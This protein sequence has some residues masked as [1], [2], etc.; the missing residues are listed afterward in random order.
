LQKLQDLMAET[1]GSNSRNFRISWQKLQELMAETSGFNGRNFRISWQL[2]II[3]F[4]QYK[5]IYTEESSDAS[6]YTSVRLQST[7]FQKST[8]LTITTI[9]TSTSVCRISAKHVCFEELYFCNH[10]TESNGTKM[11]IATHAWN[12]CST[13]S[14]VNFLYCARHWDKKYI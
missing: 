12:A 4:Y 6:L 8:S 13:A 2:I 11:R 3:L 5:N 1:S 9:R 10:G 14:H 7:T